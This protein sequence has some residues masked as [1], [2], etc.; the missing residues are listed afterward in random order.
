MIALQKDITV[1][2]H[3]GV[4]GRVATK[5][6]QIAQEHEVSLY[7]LR[8]DEE[9]DCTSV[10]DILSMGFAC[11]TCVR[12]RVQGDNAGQAIADIENLL[13]TNIEP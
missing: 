11:G 10:L 1:N 6:A 12:F 9:L 4:H 13:S 3:H 2:V 5:L 7:I 8:D